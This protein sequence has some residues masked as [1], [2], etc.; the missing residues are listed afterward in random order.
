[1]LRWDSPLN[2]AHFLQIAVTT[3]VPSIAV[4]SAFIFY[5]LPL[6]CNVFALGNC[7]R[8]LKLEYQLEFRVPVTIIEYH[9]EYQLESPNSREME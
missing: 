9:L 1:M 8:V 6:L 4:G 3:E 5:L 7:L 2:F